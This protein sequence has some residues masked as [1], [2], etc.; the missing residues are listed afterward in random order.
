MQFDFIVFASEKRENQPEFCKFCETLSLNKELF[1][2]KFVE[3][4]R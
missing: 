1:T 3:N 4:G 2:V